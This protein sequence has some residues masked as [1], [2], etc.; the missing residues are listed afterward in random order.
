M[1]E[2]TVV[3]WVTEYGYFGIFFLL[4]FGIVGLPVPDEWL[5]VISGYLA[6]KNVL[7]LFPTFAVAILGSAFGLTM[8]YILGRT[9]SGYIIRRYGRW[10]SVDDEKI[11]RAQHWF[12]NLGRWVLVVGPFIPGVRNLM[13]YIAGASKLR[14]HIF[15]RFAYLGAFISSVTFVTFGYAVG[16]HVDWAYSRIALIAVA[17]AVIFTASGLPVRIALRIR[18]IAAAAIANRPILPTAAIAQLACDPRK[19]PAPTQVSDEM[20]A[21][22]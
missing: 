3:R 5:L 6:F 19:Y 16:Q 20:I 22:E 18:K 11:Q 10:L 2:Q 21:P 4:I 7:G 8:S 12:Q 1:T 15:A 14:L 9:S 17:G 13:G